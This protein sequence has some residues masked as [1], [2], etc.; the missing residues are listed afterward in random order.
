MFYKLSSRRYPK[1]PI[2]WN[3]SEEK[4]SCLEF[5]IQ[6]INLTDMQLKLKVLMNIANIKVVTQQ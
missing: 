3:L 1:A 5:K 4:Q 6:I 2:T